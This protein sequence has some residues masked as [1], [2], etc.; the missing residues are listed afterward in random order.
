MILKTSAYQL[1]MSLLVLVVLG[2]CVQSKTTPGYA[3][4][5]DHIVIGLGGIERNVGGEVVLKATDLTVTLTDSASTVHTLDARFVYKSYVDYTAQINEFSFDGTNASIGLTNMVPFD[6][7][8]IVVAALTL[9]G[10]YD[11][12]L[13]L[14]VGAATVSVTS[15]KLTNI[16]NAVEGDLTAIPIEVIAGTSPED[17]DF[18]RQFIGYSPS[19]RQF[20]ISPDDLTGITE[21]GGAYVAIDYND[22]SFFGGGVEP[23]VV[24]AAHNPFVQMGYNVDSNGDGTGT[25]YVSLL[26]PAGFKTP[27]TAAN[28]SSKLSDLTLNL[29]YFPP[30][31]GSQA[32]AAK[33]NF[34]IDTVESYYVDMNG[35]VISGLTPMLDHIEDL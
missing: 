2:G 13:P 5:G 26:N 8:W 1:V 22:D 30:G 31:A 27:A 16:A 17:V 20:V 14:A 18:M 24:P 33:A 12:P 15:P 35:A 23:M 21:V 28:N 29:V 4:A 6:G 32:T 7:G 11:M 10:Q 34:S 19:L 9:P 25:I 3:R